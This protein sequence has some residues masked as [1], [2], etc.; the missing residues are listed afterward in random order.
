MLDLHSR[1]IS[2]VSIKLNDCI[3]CDIVG[4]CRDIAASSLASSFIVTVSRQWLI[5]FP[6]I[7]V[8]TLFW[9]VATYMLLLFSHCRGFIA[10]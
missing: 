2:W 4:L 8:T 10:I 7:F 6:S 3:C 9:N 5:C 1:L